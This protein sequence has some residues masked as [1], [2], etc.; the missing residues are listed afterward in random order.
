MP[1]G[2]RHGPGLSADDATAGRR[3]AGARRAARP[4]DRDPPGSS[5][6]ADALIL[7][8][9]LGVVLAGV[10][11][12]AARRLG[13]LTTGGAWAAVI[14]G[15]LVAASGWRWAVLLIGYFVLSSLLTRWGHAT[16]AART[17]AMIPATTAR[18][19][20]QVGANGGVYALAV[21][22]G[23]LTGDAHAYLAALGALAGAAADTWATEIG[24]LYGGVPRSVLTG[25]RLE[26]GA[27][28]GVTA[29][30]LAASVIAA[31]AVAATTPWALTGG[32][33]L[34]AD[35]GGTAIA[36]AVAVTIAGI[37]AS[38]ADSVLGASL[39][40][41]RWCGNCR[42]WTERTVHR[43]GTPTLQQRGL[44]WMTNDTVNLL[45]T[46]TGAIVALAAYPL[47]D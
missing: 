18:T 44:A 26:P 36:V 24:T 47:F 35:V 31:I 14:V 28:G 16:K 5:G 37:A 45:A 43:C 17:D 41:K 4:G 2:A 15:T 11:A 33:R 13:S 38:L 23:A 39:Q 29:E 25:E 20:V 34:P 19:A 27:S 1:R 22:T 21:V 32:Y 7:R 8:A 30:G 12:L 6:I 9:A 3:D 10:V 40:A 42:S 46:V